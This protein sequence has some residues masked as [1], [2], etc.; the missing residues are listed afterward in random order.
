[1]GAVTFE[2]IDDPDEQPAIP[3][4]WVDR[5]T[6]AAVCVAILAALLLFT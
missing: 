3:K 5:L 2:P 6:V 1:M 4:K